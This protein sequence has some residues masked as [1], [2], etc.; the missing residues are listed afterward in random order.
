MYVSYDYDYEGDQVA[1]MKWFKIANWKDCKSLEE[2]DNAITVPSWL[3]AGRAVFRWDWSALHVHPAIEFYAQCADVQVNGSGQSLEVSQ[4]PSYSIMGVYPERHGADGWTQ[5]WR[6][7]FTNPSD[8][9]MTGP[10]CACKNDPKNGCSYTDSA[11]TTEGYISKPTITEIQCGSSDNSSPV[12]APTPNPTPNPTAPVASPTP[13]PSAPA[14]SPVQAPTSNPDDG[15]CAVA[16]AKCGG[17]GWTGATC[18]EAGYYC[19]KE[20]EWY[21]GCKPVG[22]APTANSTPEPTPQPTHQPTPQ[23]TNAPTYAPTITTPP[24]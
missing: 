3:P 8:T 11:A 20:T 5:G 7:A 6:N 18:C 16:W 4:V 13:P 19:E 12:A 24:V 21:S 9:W 14:A 2:Q 1:D 15:S 22:G 10:P 23:P 17:L